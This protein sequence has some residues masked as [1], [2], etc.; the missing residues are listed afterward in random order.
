MKVGDVVTAVLTAFGK[1]LERDVLC[2]NYVYKAHMSPTL[3]KSPVIH[4]EVICYQL[5][6]GK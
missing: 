3:D 2:Y 1:Y 5:E 6:F 4:R